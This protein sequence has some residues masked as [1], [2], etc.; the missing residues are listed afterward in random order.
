MR[1][2]LLVLSFMLSLNA[3]A[4]DVSQA[5]PMT[6]PEQ[7]S[8][9]DVIKTVVGIHRKVQFV[10][11]EGFTELE[12]ERLRHIASNV[13]KIINGDEI[14][15]LLGKHFVVPYT[16]QVVSFWDVKSP[17]NMSWRGAWATTM[18]SD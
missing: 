8:I 18:R 7:P 14:E 1:K 5:S 11:L 12:K 10:N 9:I 4:Q 2:L 3:S 13:E 6:A 17:L 15:T 16:K